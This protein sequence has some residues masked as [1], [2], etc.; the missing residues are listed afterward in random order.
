MIT[1]ISLRV[2][3]E[4]DETTIEF[5][6]G[7]TSFVTLL[8]VTLGGEE[9]WELHPMGMQA[10]PSNGGAFFAVPVADVNGLRHLLAD[11]NVDDEDRFEPVNQ[12]TYGLVP[13]GYA[14][15]APAKPL[16]EGKTY[17]VLV[18]RVPEYGTVD[19]VA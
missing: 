18:L 19:F 7:S 6:E 8:V 13:H 16:T 10:A 11:L 3:H 1:E 12:I 4:E 17:R 9:M 14:E 2:R 5:V 15:V